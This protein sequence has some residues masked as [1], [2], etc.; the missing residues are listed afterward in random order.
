MSEVASQITGVSLVC[1]SK[2]TSKLRVTGLCVGEFTA[3]RC[4][5]TGEFPAQKASNVETVSIS[6]RHHDKW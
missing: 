4:P 5:V 2:K 1:G 6:R 3:E